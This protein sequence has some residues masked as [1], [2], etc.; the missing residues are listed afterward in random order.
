MQRLISYFTEG[1]E[2]QTLDT[3]GTEIE[4]QFVNKIRNPIARIRSQKMLQYLVIKYG[5]SVGCKKGNLITTIFDSKGNKILYE[6]GRHNI[7]ISTIPSTV[8]G[9]LDEAKKCLSQ[10]YEVARMIGAEPYFAPILPGEEDLL[11]I[12]DERDAIWIELDGREALAPLA[13]ISAVQFT[14]SVAPQDAIKILN[15][16]GEQINKFLENF[17]QDTIW[18]Q[19]IRESC[20][21]Y[22]PNRYGGPLI[23][24]DL[25]DYCCALTE[26]DVVQGVCLVPY[27]KVNNL[28]IPLYLRSIWWHFRLKRYGNAL[29]IEV[30]PMARRSDE[31]LQYQLEQVLNIVCD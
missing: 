26:H 8:T 7:E 17:P 28:D 2:S 4:T 25:Y 9:V 3:V 13:R 23:F 14:I 1:I 15:R 16:L 21:G 19:Y 31:Q 24:N 22:L 12:P 29:C 30:R 18:K 20:A 6:L 27:S 5:W 10:I 11:I